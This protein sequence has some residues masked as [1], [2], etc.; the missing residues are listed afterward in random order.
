MLI[1]VE[2]EGDSADRARRRL[3]TRAGASFALL[4]LAAMRGL[5]GVA[6]RRSPRACNPLVNGKFAWFASVLG[7]RDRRPWV[8][9]V[10]HAG[11]ADPRTADRP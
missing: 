5:S 9:P 2:R 7:L 4:R 1:S 10:T 8:N 3:R 11:A 6:I